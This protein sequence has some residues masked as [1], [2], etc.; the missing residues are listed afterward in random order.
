MECSTFGNQTPQ[1]DVLGWG[2]PSFNIPK[3]VCEYHLQEGFKIK[4]I[5]SMLSVSESTVY[6]RMWSYG[7]SAHNSSD[8]CDNE[9]DCHLSELLKEFPF[10]GEGLM[11]FLLWERGIK[12]QRM[13]LRNRIDHVDEK[14][15]SERKKGC[16]QC[17]AQTIP[18]WCK[19]Q[20]CKVELCHNR[21]SWSW[22]VNCQLFWNAQT[23]TRQ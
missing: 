11:T 12:V 16:L 17:R 1:R 15:V 2:A 23:I 20:T 10:C 14:E 5:A 9:L 13:R 18:Y 4:D 21:C 7:L 19:P 22:K 6:Q 3:S 8:I